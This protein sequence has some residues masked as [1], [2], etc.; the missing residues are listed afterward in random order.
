PTGGA[1]LGTPASATLT[2]VD[3]DPVPTGG[4]GGGAF[5]WAFLL[6]GLLLQLV[7]HPVVTDAR[8]AK[9]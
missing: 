7:R 9:A 6:F 2:I 4:G 5:G 1:S 3:D 8:R